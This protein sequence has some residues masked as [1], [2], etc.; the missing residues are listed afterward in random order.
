M[1]LSELSERSGVSVASVKYY[2]REGLLQPGAAVSARRSEYDEDHLRRLRLVRALL[3]VGGMSVAQARDVL[4]AAQDPAFDRHSRLG[5]AQYLLP[6][7]VTTPPAGTPEAAAWQERRAEVLALLRDE[8]GWR[9]HDGAPALDAL[10]EALLT[11]NSLG[12]AT[13]EG[14]LRDYANAL[15]PIAEAELDVID[16]HPAIDEAI[17]A[18]VAYTVL[19][20]PVL[21]S[22]RRLAHEDVSARRRR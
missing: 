1:Q 9:I 14:T 7:R 11:L 21:L 12:Y 13:T 18:V 20:E 8:L 6:P 17:E 2:L 4:A 3:T 15:H 10:T 19:Y 16:E 5:V 22:L